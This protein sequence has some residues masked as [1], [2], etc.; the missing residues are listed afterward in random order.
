MSRFHI[1][2]SRGSFGFITVC[3]TQEHALAE[4]R[5]LRARSGVW[6]VHIEDAQGSL[7]V[8][9]FDL[10]AGRRSAAATGSPVSCA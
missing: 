5:A 9:D 4:A 8:G 10:R 1:V 7:V 6:H 2:Y 3:D